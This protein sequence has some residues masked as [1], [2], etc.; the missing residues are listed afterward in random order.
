MT[1]HEEQ[2]PIDNVLDQLMGQSRKLNRLKRIRLY[3]YQTEPNF[4]DAHGFKFIAGLRQ[5][6]KQSGTGHHVRINLEY[7]FKIR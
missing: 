6:P 3:W 5:A 4:D 2:V 7:S 1:W